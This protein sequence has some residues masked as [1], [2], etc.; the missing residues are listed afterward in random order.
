AQL[1]GYRHGDLL[2]RMVADVDALQNLHLRGVG[3]RMVALL[4]AAVSV[5][6]T[7]AFLPAAAAVLAVG[8]VVAGVAVPALAV[9]LE[10]RFGAPGAEARGALTAELVETLRGAPELAVYGREDEQLGRL[11][12]SDRALARVARRAAVVDGAGDGLR[13]LVTGATVAGV[14]VVAVS[15][16]AA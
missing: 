11:R 15:A 8:L 13:L 6:V 12:G 16:H 5:A 14:L 2:A 3:P 4:V 9:R 1:E 10:R 7:A